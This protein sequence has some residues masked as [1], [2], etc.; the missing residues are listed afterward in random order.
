M[1]PPVAP[2]WY[3]VDLTATITSDIATPDV[4]VLLLRQLDDAVLAVAA[5]YA[6][7]ALLAGACTTAL[8][9]TRRFAAVLPPGARL[10]R[11]RLYRCSAMQATSPGAA[12]GA[13]TF[14]STTFGLTGPTVATVGVLPLGHGDL[15]WET[16]QP[17]CIVQELVVA[18]GFDPAPTG[19]A[20]R[21]VAVDPQL[22]AYREVCE[23]SHFAGVGVW[24]SEY[25]DLEAL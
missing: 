17:Q 12:L 19:T 14:A 23:V 3:T 6:Q 7:P 5:T 18:P 2:N 10:A 15:Y 25:A 11:A 4:S 13:S 1:R 9:S 24:V 21:A 16:A 22:T 8:G 20:N